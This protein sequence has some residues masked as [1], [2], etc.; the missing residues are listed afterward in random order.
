MLLDLL[1]KQAML[2]RINRD[3]IHKAN[4]NKCLKTLEKR[5]RLN[6]LSIKK[7][8]WWIAVTSSG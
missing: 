3:K 5:F 6:L 8:D 2:A 1:P 4:N 7:I